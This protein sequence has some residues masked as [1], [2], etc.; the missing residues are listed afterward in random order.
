[1]NSRLAF[2]LAQIHHY[3]PQRV[4]YR[5]LQRQLPGLRPTILL[6]LRFYARHAALHCTLHDQ[7]GSLIAVSFSHIDCLPSLQFPFGNAVMFL[8]HPNPRSQTL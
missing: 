7:H 2:I 5:L 3:S 6:Q 1:M 8:F 4:Y